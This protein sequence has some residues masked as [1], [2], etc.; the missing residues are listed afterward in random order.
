MVIQI[1]T[2]RS[3]ESILSYLVLKFHLHL[4]IKLSN[5]HHNTK[6]Y[7]LNDIILSCDKIPIPIIHCQHWI[8]K[9]TNIPMCNVVNPLIKFVIHL[10]FLITNELYIF[11]ESEVSIMTT[12]INMCRNAGM[13]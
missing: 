6:F 5:G 3:D 10:S 8:F 1:K 11:T 2:V 12:K 4:Q 7:H 9:F 13:L